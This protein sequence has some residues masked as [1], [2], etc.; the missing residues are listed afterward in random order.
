[1][2]VR[3]WKDVNKLF[4][5]RVAYGNSFVRSLELGLVR[6]PDDWHAKDV[7]LR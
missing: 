5:G 6:T 1:M 3:Q 7:F 2:V 4:W